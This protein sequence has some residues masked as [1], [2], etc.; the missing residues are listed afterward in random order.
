M[1]LYISNLGPQVTDESLHAIFAT[2]GTVEAAT[3]IFDDE[4]GTSRGIAFVVMPND[5]QAQHAITR[6]HGC[7]LNGLSVSV[8]SAISLVTIGASAA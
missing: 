1:H 5:L 7:V 2:Y 8:E 6:I 3:V 4:S